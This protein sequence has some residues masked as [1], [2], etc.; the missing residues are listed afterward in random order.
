[1]VRGAMQ[2]LGVAALLVACIA[3]LAGAQ[4]EDDDNS[5]RFCDIVY[6]ETEVIEK[7]NSIAELKESCTAQLAD[8]V[9]HFGP[10]RDDMFHEV[11][12]KGDCDSYHNSYVD[13]LEQSGCTC[14]EAGSYDKYCYET[15]MALVCE[16]PQLGMCDNFNEP[17]DTDPCLNT[18]APVQASLVLV[19][20]SAVA[21]W[22]AQARH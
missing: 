22:T 5:T 19:V 16:M 15:R 3:T 4:T 2:R 12:C 18:A 20:A 6:F 21:L 13:L 1:M 9:E 17:H 7:Q 10:P 8:L 11:L 14:Q